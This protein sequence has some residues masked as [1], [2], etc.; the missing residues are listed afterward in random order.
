[1]ADYV[2]V[3]ETG[4]IVAEGPAKDLAASEEVK[5]AYLGG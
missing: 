4:E 3:F 5:K 2:Y 1:M